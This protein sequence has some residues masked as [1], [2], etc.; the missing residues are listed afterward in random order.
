MGPGATA[1]AAEELGAVDGAVD[2][3]IESGLL[4]RS[5]VLESASAAAT[6]A[7]GAPI[8]LMG[9]GSGRAKFS[10]AE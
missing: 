9:K 4:A 6:T 3:A 5:M 10:S 2:G 8:M 7:A 1:T